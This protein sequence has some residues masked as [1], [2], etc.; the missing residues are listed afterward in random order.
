MTIEKLSSGSY[1]IRQQYHGTRYSLIVPYKPNKRE[2]EEL[3]R[4]Y[5]DKPVSREKMNFRQAAKEY[6]EIKKHVLSP[7]SVKEYKLLINRYTEWFLKENINRIDDRLIQK[8]VNEMAIDL[9]PKT[10]KD[11]YGFISAVVT[12][13]RQGLHISVT[14]P[15]AVK[16]DPYIPTPEEVRFILE[17][18]KEHA[19]YF[20]IPIAL[21]SSC[22]LRRSEIFA[23]K[24]ENIVDG[25]L[26]ID[27][28]IVQNEKGEWIEKGTKTTDSTRR[29]P[30]AP[31]LAKMIIDQGY[32]Y[33]GG[34]Q[35]ISNY[36]HR[37]CKKLDI[38]EFS[39]HKLRHFYASVLLSQGVPMKDVAALGGWKNLQTLEKIYAHA[40]TT[41]TDEQKTTIANRLWNE[42]F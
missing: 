20:Y 21:A 33:D 5:L 9:S 32:A 4:N 14:L 3:I 41:R 15:Q 12:T 37:I 1:R 18:T 10:V 30:V 28:A 11:R 29:V 25:M 16:K 23:L 13:F 38:G 42:I 31:D 17:Y 35:S 7:R 27:S 6:I 2:A 36:L 19:P 26:I 40:M 39:L 22:G 34:S 24:A 8:C